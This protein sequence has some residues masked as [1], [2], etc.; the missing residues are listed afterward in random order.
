MIDEE[1][2]LILMEDTLKEMKI[3]IGPRIKLLK[4]IKFQASSSP[5][6]TCQPKENEAKPSV[7]ANQSIFESCGAQTFQPR[8]K[9]RND[10]NI[11]SILEESEVGV[12]VIC[13]LDTDKLS[14]KS[15]VKMVQTSKSKWQRQW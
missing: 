13:E 7:A 12:Q 1:A 11:K 6:F 15:R 4:K 5:E 14:R 8:K 9:P 3:P 2:F 10:F